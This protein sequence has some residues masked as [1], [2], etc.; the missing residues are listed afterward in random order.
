M[1]REWD[2]D[3]EEDEERRCRH[4]KRKYLVKRWQMV[5]HCPFCGAAQMHGGAVSEPE[6]DPRRDHP[7]REE[8]G[9][10]EPRGWRDRRTQGL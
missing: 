6:S 3:P 5:R 1:D 4:C 8:F 2:G 9:R 7:R 10:R